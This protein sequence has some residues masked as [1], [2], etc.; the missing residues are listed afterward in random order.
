MKL[1]GMTDKET[2]NEKYLEVVTKIFEEQ[3]EKIKISDSLIDY[4]DE[5]VEIELQLLHQAVLAVVVVMEMEHQQM[6]D[7]ELEPE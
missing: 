3:E 6:V 5:I 1:L 4:N 2:S 7:P